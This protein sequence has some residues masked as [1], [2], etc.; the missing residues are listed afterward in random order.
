MPR[1]FLGRSV[2]VLDALM[3]AI[4][5]CKGSTGM[6]PTKMDDFVAV[7]FSV[8]YCRRILGLMAIGFLLLSQSSSSPSSPPYSCW[9]IFFGKNL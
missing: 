5:Y 7:G 6:S 2:L 8:V 1:C 4:G 3:L 9:R